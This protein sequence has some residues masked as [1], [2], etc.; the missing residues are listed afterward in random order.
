[1]EIHVGIDACESVY[2]FKSYSVLFL[3]IIHVVCIK[4]PQNLAPC[5][6]HKGHT[7]I[8]RVTT[9]Q[10]AVEQITAPGSL[11]NAD[12][13]SLQMFYAPLIDSKEADEPQSRLLSDA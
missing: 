6:T 7:A 9:Y 4:K 8:S 11:P 13:T 3:E 12:H 5:S 10:T 2:N 1:M